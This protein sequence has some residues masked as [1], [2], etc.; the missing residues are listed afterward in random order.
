MRDRFYWVYETQLL[1]KLSSQLKL[2]NFNALIFLSK[3]K[4]NILLFSVL[5][6]FLVH[7]ILNS[8]KF[9]MHGPMHH[10]LKNLQKR[11]KA[12]K[13]EKNLKMGS[14]CKMCKYPIFVTLLVMYVVAA[15]LAI[16]TGGF[17]IEASLFPDRYNW[18]LILYFLNFF[19]SQTLRN[20][21]QKSKDQTSKDLGFRSM[22]SLR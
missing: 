8:N 5:F 4:L 19:E 2:N 7:S 13:K 21:S 16:F 20:L 12:E 14:S 1:L 11:K 9:C 18:Y 17:L 10:I 3:Q 22:Y 15:V 6:R